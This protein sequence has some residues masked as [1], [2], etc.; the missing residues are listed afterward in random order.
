L[1]RG[2]FQPKPLGA[3][4]AS[5]SAPETSLRRTLGPLQLTLL[6]IGAIIG[7]GI[8][9][10]VGTAAAGGPDHLGAGPALVL[11]FVLTAIACGFAAL[12]YAE[13]ASMVPIS[14]SAYTYAYATLGELIG[15]IIGWDL[16]I[17]YAV[18]NVAVAISWAGYFQ[19][20]LRGF[21]IIFPDWLATDLRTAV[22]SAHQVAAARAAGTDPATLGDAVAQGARALAQAP[23]L[24]GLPVVFNLPAF[25]I[26]ML[27]TW[28]LVI[29]IRESAW[30]NSSMVVLKLVIITVFVV[31]GG[32]YVKPANWHPFAPN[33]FAGISA[34]AA[35]IFFAYIGFDAVS[36]AAEETRDPRRDMPI[37]II[38]SLVVCTVIY[39]AVALVLTGMVP[40]RQLGTA[41][42]LA[43]AFSTLGM[44][45]PA[46]FISL[47]AVFATTSVLVVFQLGQPRIFFS[48][49]RD[50]LLPQWAARVHPRYRTPH[51]TTLI[52]GVA[53]AVFAGLLNIN[54]VVEL[55]NIGTLFAF[56][57]VCVGI[58]ILRHKDPLRPRPFRVPLG[59]WLLPVLGAAS[60][61]F[62]MMRLPATS[63]WRFIGW[64]LL[65]MSVYFSYGYSQSLVGREM[66]RPSR[67]P[68]ALRVAALGFLLLAAGLFT[69]PH[70]ASLPAMVSEALPP[71]GPAP[72]PDHLRAL[73]G[74][75]AIAAG[76][77]LGGG[78][79]LAEWRRR[80]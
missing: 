14:G 50:G 35:I 13:F 76:L 23:H 60:C 67:T 63:W 66:G 36:T 42:P 29:G 49:A 32:F 77:V 65:G 59:P 27:V 48:M 71:P 68:A 52:T 9:S 41:E 25:L 58:I 5:A 22:E 26:V 34:A 40:W 4:L 2:I 30:F 64:L 8:F 72:P 3:I 78:G 37:A 20:L 57:L 16:I 1:L 51:I 6:G 74:L 12:C 31:L 33:G 7:A 46:V 28:V 19:E 38:S 70:D 79:L 53:V 69:I 24:G 45:W 75:T 54:E 17:E 44:K 15:W 56:V 80:G 11:S 39:I 73:F 61:L 18:G 47:G 10:T 55:T 43:S 62:L 21:G